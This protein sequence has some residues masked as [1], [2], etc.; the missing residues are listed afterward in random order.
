VIWVFR[1]SKWCSWKL[2]CTGTLHSVT[3]C[4]L[5]SVS[6]T[7][8]AIASYKGSMMQWGTS[9][10]RPLTHKDEA[11]IKSRNNGQITPSEG[12][13]YH[14]IREFSLWTVTHHPFLSTIF[15]II[16]TFCFIPGR[17]HKFINKQTKR[18]EQKQQP[19]WNK[20]KGLTSK[21]VWDTGR[22]KVLLFETNRSKIS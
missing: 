11:T 18:T 5:P 19:V 20:Y 14:Q 16:L 2:H 22:H 7:I 3:A 10:T 8:Y 6:N 1:L 13:Q 9:C 15:G 21:L 17:L 12:A 4:S